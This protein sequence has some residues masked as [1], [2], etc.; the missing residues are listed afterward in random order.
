[1]YTCSVA[2]AATRRRGKRKD[3]RKTAVQEAN[4]Q[5]ASSETK[6]EEREGRSEKVDD[7]R[8]R[9][10]KQ[11]KAMN[12]TT[13]QPISRD[14][15]KQTENIHTHMHKLATPKEEEETQAK[16]QSLSI[17]SFFKLQY[18]LP[19]PIHPPTLLLPPQG[20]EAHGVLGPLQGLSSNGVSVGCAFGQHAFNHLR[21]GHDLFVLVLKGGWV[22]GW[23]G[24]WML[25]VGSEYVGGR[26]GRER[27]SWVGGYL[28]GLQ[29]GDDGLG[30]QGLEGAPVHPFYLLED[31][32]LA[33]AGHGLV[34]V[35]EVGAF[36]PVRVVPL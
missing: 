2:K 13:S 18:A 3:K 7:R 26:G 35:Q 12:D 21:V 30:E 31:A 33:F 6:D 5:P 11:Q 14:R 25:V 23:E 10:H 9:N 19:L 4:R 20:I 34:D 8:R 15:E 22:G 16:N 24:G 36:G 32:L 27:G 28:D 29:V 1:M 17:V